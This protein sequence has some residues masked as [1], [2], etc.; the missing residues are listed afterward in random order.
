MLLFNKFQEIGIP[1]PFVVIVLDAGFTLSLE[2][3][4]GLAQQFGGFRI[5]VIESGVFGIE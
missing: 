1:N 4:D 3:L 5:Q 2:P